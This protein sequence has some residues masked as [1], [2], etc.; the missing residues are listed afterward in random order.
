MQ[1]KAKSDGDAD[2]RND[3]EWEFHD[4]MQNVDAQVGAQYGKDSNEYQSLGLKK[5]SEYKKRGAKKPPT[6]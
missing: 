2:I 4:F 3:D 6:P 5:K 1:S